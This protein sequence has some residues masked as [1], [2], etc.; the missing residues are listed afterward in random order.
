MTIINNRY[1]EGGALRKVLVPVGIDAP[2]PGRVTIMKIYKG[3]R[4]TGHSYYD[5]AAQFI[6]NSL[7]MEPVPL[8]G[9][10]IRF[11]GDSRLGAEVNITKVDK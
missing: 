2:R 5:M 10:L 6:F 1:L 8:Q 4:Y 9:E 11:I 7:F 3:V